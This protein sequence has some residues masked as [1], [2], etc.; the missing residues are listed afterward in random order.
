MRVLI[1]AALPR[2]SRGLLPWLAVLLA[3]LGCGRTPP[4]L[5]S[6]AEAANT[7][8]AA[9]ARA[10]AYLA[11][12]SGGN[13]AERRRAAFLWGLFACEASSPR[14]AHRAFLLAQPSAARGRLAARRLGEALSASKAATPDWWGAVAA[15]WMAPEDRDRL[16]VAGAEDRLGAGDLVG[17]AE[18][19]RAVERGSERP[20]ALALLATAGG[21]AAA[22]AERQLAVEYPTRFGQLLPGRSLSRVTATFTTSEWRRHAEAW[23]DAGVA[24]PA[25]GAAARSNSALLAARAAN[26]LRRA[27]NALVWAGRLDDTDPDGWIERAE[28]HRQIAWGGS[29]ERRAGPFREMLRC[30]RRA[31]DLLAASDPRSGRARLQIAEALTELGRFDEAIRQFAEE[32]VRSQPRHDW[33]LRRLFL[34]RGRTAVAWPEPY[35]PSRAATNRVRRIAAY[36]VGV[37]AESVGSVVTGDRLATSGFPDL[38]AHWAARASGVASPALSLR[39]DVMVTPAPPPWAADLIAAGRV[40]DAIVAWR[41]DLEAESRQG[42]EWLGLLHLAEMAPLDEIPLLV[43]AEPRL[44]TGPWDGL[45]RQLLERYLPL[46][47]RDEIEDASRRAGVPPWLLAGLVRQ[48]SA[49]SPAARSAVGAVGL[50]Q[51]LPPV[52]REIVGRD[53]ALAR[54]L[55]GARRDADLTRPRANLGIGAT[56]LRRW[57]DSLGGS[58]TAALACYNAGERR[59]REVWERSG[60]RDGPEF[61]EA[62]EIPETWDYVHRV[63]LLAEGYRLLYWPMES[64][65]PWT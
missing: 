21:S 22:P 10:R 18:L 19:A 57:R 52:A 58:W 4:A 2:G 63:V 41:A 54:W 61:V 11:V 65:Y 16:L 6:L 17:A 20:R 15:P 55:G 12:A 7:R 45:H 32:G 46:P 49:W 31:A 44:V 42:P 3:L 27:H 39:E 35:D 5:P 26:R 59:V 24:A 38:P 33:V 43:R 25:Y 37:R 51:L 30:S 64:P 28:A 23:L 47:Y 36:W 60:R 56:L 8:G 50:S 13:P 62:I 34:L 1:P 53:A 40:S 14:S 29:Q 48:E 9:E